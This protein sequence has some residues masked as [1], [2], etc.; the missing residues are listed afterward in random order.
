MS[1]RVGGI[2]ILGHIQ[3]LPGQGAERPD[4][5]LELALLAQGLGRRPPDVPPNLNPSVI[6]IEFFLVFM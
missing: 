6:Y 1:C 2:S 5:A 4:L 3:N